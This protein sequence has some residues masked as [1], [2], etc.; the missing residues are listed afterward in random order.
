MQKFKRNSSVIFCY[1]MSMEIVSISLYQLS[2]EAYFLNIQMQ[3]Q[4]SM[5]IIAASLSGNILLQSPSITGAFKKDQQGKRFNLG[6]GFAYKGRQSDK[7]SGRKNPQQTPV[8]QEEAA[9]D[10]S[11]DMLPLE[12]IM[13]EPPDGGVPGENE[14]SGLDLCMP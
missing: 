9:A 6:R 3:P 4:R 1:E 7:P 10:E 13:G 8:W 5:R 11:P 2:H 14:L 12:P